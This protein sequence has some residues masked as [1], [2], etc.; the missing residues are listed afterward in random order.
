MPPWPPHAPRYSPATAAKP[1]GL[2]KSVALP[3]SV[4]EVAIIAIQ[5]RRLITPAGESWDSWFDGPTVTDD[6][7]ADREQP[8]GQKRE[9][10]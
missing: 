8:T 4:K 2:P 5:N 1:S 10:L 6:F 9:T 3:E 7:M